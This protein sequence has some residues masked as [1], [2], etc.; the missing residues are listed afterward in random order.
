MVL[1]EFLGRNGRFDA[2]FGEELVAEGGRELVEGDYADAGGLG[3]GC[4]GLVEGV[5]DDFCLLENGAVGQADFGL[6]LPEEGGFFCGGGEADEAEGRKREGEEGAAHAGTLG[7]KDPVGKARPADE[8]R[9]Y[10]CRAVSGVRVTG[11]R[12]PL[13]VRGQ[14]LASKGR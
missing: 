1:R 3:D 5:V 9:P 10:G 12:R 8:R 6:H 11:P 13:G 4:G 2:G 14:A 7:G